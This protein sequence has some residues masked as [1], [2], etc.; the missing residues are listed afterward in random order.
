MGFADISNQCVASMQ[1]LT[2][3]AN[4]LEEGQADS[5]L[6]DHGNKVMR[7][8][9]ESNRKFNLITFA[10]NS[11]SVFFNSILDESS[12]SIVSRL[13][14][15]GF[16]GYID[17]T[18]R[19]Y[20]LLVNDKQQVF[21]DAASLLNALP[22]DLVN[23]KSVGL[24]K[25][26]NL[27]PVIFNV[28]DKQ[29][30][31]FLDISCINQM[32]NHSPVLMVAAPEKYSL[33]P[34]ER[35]AY[36][37]AISNATYLW[38]NILEALPDQSSI[39]HWLQ[40]AIPGNLKI[41]PAWRHQQGSQLAVLLKNESA[42]EVDAINSYNSIQHAK[43]FADMLD[44]SMSDI[45]DS[46]A[47]QLQANEV[48]LEIAGN[49]SDYDD[50][51]QS[52]RKSVSVFKD[53]VGGIQKNLQTRSRHNLAGQ[54]VYPQLVDSALAEVKEE[55]LTR[56]QEHKSF[57][58]ELSEQSLS[59]IKEDIW[60]DIIQRH[61][62]ETREYLDGIKQLVNDSE[63]GKQTFMQSF[64]SRLEN[65]EGE[66]SDIN[67]LKTLLDFKARYKG[68]MQQRGFLK[69]LGEGRRVVFMILMIFS[70]GG[71]M[72][73][74]NYREYSMIGVMFLLVFLGS[75]FYTFISWKKDE[76]F[77]LKKEIEKA[78]DQIRMDVLRSITDVERERLNRLNDWF[79]ESFQD[80][81]RDFED[82]RIVSQK[83]EKQR[84]D[85]SRSMTKS[86]DTKLQSRIRELDKFRQEIAKIKQQFE[87][88]EQQHIAEAEVIG[89]R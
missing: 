36:I 15:K 3:F 46:A 66:L 35:G 11:L 23:L 67:Q 50:Q 8:S 62:D 2:A 9:E 63:L 18:E 55:D 13:E 33:I 26:D 88:M 54:H 89:F 6:R 24:P 47:F 34:E 41:I 78:R 57:R 64:R 31:L 27:A 61:D 21:S 52:I 71:S 48:L 53:N 44:L 30:L 43:R 87:Q 74:F 20:Y 28:L 56:S 40:E 76:K 7:V 29:A 1:Q 68:E 37:Q 75:S 77:Q 22:A 86:K 42:L 58:L 80:L 59:G 10:D 32:V 69:R 83:D 49:T 16:S 73:G 17:L 45:S 60:K 38:P 65:D 70:I 81:Q 4:N 72:V 5:P 12:L 79:Q 85:Q 84:I 39:Q 14:D 19:Q 51:T 82:W 25:P